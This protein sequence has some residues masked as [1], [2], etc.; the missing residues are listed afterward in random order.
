MV[1]AQRFCSWHMGWLCPSSI[2]MISSSVSSTTHRKVR[3]ILHSSKN[4]K[5]N[6][7]RAV[8][9]RSSHTRITSPLHN[10]RDML[11]SMDEFQMRTSTWLS[12]MIMGIL[13]AYCLPKIQKG[14]S[15]TRKRF[16][17]GLLV[18]TVGF[19]TI[20]CSIISLE[21]SNVTFSLL[22]AI[23]P[24]GAGLIFS[25][26]IFMLHPETQLINYKLTPKT[27]P[28]LVHFSRLSYTL[29]ITHYAVLV[30]IT[31]STS[32]TPMFDTF[33]ILC[34]SAGCLAVIYFVSVFLYIFVER[35]IQNIRKIIDV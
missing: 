8:S 13:F 35:P 27:L 24:I 3:L 2:F 15:T 29:Y 7:L 19:Y 14:S 20:V 1:S 30:T 26:M 12:P 33:S 23:A 10:Y 18:S 32:F 4:M 6:F 22:E 34:I 17:I 5:G 11:A 21:Q 25:S 9:S 31:N 28:S 16:A